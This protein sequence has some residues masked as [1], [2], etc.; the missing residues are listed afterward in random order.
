VR[1]PL[2]GGDGT[3]PTGE[4]AVA[5]APV[6]GDRPSVGKAVFSEPGEGPDV[7]GRQVAARDEQRGRAGKPALP[8]G[9]AEH[10]LGA[11]GGSHPPEDRAGHAPRAAVNGPGADHESSAPSPRRAVRAVYFGRA[12]TIILPASRPLSV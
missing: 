8:Q 6:Q 4:V 9:T 5:S 10:L 1:S 11:H 12:A 3:G 7:P 2:P